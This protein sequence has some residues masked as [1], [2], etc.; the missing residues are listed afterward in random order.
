MNTYATTAVTIH[1]R[2]SDESDEGVK[3][4]NDYGHDR[5]KGE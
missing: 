1:A 4:S 2:P 5:R 3:M